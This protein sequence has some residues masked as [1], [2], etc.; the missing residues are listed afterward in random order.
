MRNPERQRDGSDPAE[1]TEKLRPEKEIASFEGLLE[2]QSGNSGEAQEGQEKIEGEQLLEY[3]RKVGDFYT[4]YIESLTKTGEAKNEVLDELSAEIREKYKG[5]KQSI[6]HDREL[7]HVRFSLKD[8]G[9][10]E[11]LAESV[12]HKSLDEALIE[13]E[14]QYELEE[15]SPG[16]FVVNLETELYE[17]LYG[18]C[19]A[20]ASIDPNG[21]SFISLRREYKEKEV[22][23]K[24]YEENLIHEAH[25]VAWSSLLKDK[26]VGIREKDNNMWYAY[27]FFQDELLAR[28]TSNTGHIGYS[29]LLLMDMGHFKRP[30]DLT[31]EKEE[32]IRKRTRDLNDLLDEV[33]FPALS[34]VGLG[35]KDLIMSVMEASN[36]DELGK[37]LKKFKAAMDE[38]E[39]IEKS[40]EDTE[41][42]G[43]GTIKT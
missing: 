15:V 33:I 37:N 22:F 42:S 19:V 2:R 39:P 38:R 14:S 31:S 21:V 11:L 17:K 28:L 25:H 18:K 3:S 27:R 8:G 1:E 10:K 13:D 35:H 41:M 34:T 4:G 26:K 29:H 9:V 23:K 5:Y 43:W 6:D 7:Q 36:F 20:Y 16:F 30:A 40:D 32:E 24:A 12:R